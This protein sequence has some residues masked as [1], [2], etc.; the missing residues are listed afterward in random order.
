MPW[1]R[2]GGGDGGR[3]PL[4]VPG[5]RVAWKRWTKTT[6]NRDYASFRTRRSRRRAV[7]TSIQKNLTP[8]P[9]RTEPPTCRDKT[10]GAL[11]PRES[12]RRE[13][14][15]A[16]NAH[17]TPVG[18]VP[19]PR[20]PGLPLSLPHPRRPSGRE[21]GRGDSCR[22]GRGPGRRT[23]HEKPLPCGERCG[24]RCGAGESSGR[25]K[26]RSQSVLVRVPREEGGGDLRGR[27]K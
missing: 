25:G 11:T 20:P 13:K 10:P 6:G 24:E 17:L 23:R 16:P 26:D 9:P 3:D 7:K 1:G 22:A 18:V 2:N 27:L 19:V 8:T 21:S 12:G 14:G 4:G 5:R 15:T